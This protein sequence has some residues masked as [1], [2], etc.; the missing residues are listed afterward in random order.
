MVWLCLVK[1]MQDV[2]VSKHFLE[3]IVGVKRNVFDNLTIGVN[4]SSL[5]DYNN[6]AKEV[7]L[8]SDEQLRKMTFDE[9]ID[10]LGYDYRDPSGNLI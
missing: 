5:G 9:F 3:R 10:V 8:L 4:V 1:G 6:I 7:S 2:H